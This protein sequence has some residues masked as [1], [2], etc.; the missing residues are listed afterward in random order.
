MGVTA[1]LVMR[2]KNWANM[3]QAVQATGRKLRS[4]VGGGIGRGKGTS[5]VGLVSHFPSRGK[6]EGL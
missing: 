2:L 3:G 5:T 4:S 6:S 1:S